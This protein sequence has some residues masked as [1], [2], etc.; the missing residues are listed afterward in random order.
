MPSIQSRVVP[1]TP[2]EDERLASVVATCRSRSPSAASFLTGTYRRFENL[3]EESCRF[4]AW[5]VPYL[6]RYIFPLSSSTGRNNKSC[7]KRWLHSLDP[8]LRKGERKVVRIS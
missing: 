6:L 8:N 3:L 7:R 2:E 4:D 5:F 1:W